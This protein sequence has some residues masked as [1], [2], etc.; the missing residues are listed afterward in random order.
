MKNTTLWITDEFKAKLY[1]MKRHDQTYQQF[2]E[3]ILKER[4][5]K[6]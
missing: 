2:F 1:K 3:Q 5:N 6:K 4:G